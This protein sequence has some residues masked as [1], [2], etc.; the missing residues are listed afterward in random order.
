[1]IKKLTLLAMAI[2]AL[3]AFAAPAAAQAAEA[4]EGANKLAIGS[5]IT[6][7]STNLVTHSAL[8]KLECAKVTIHGELTENGPTVKG[9]ENSTTIEGCN[10]TITDPTAGTVSLS[11]GKGSTTGT[12]FVVEGFCSFTGSIPFSY[13]SGTD[14][15]TITGSNQLTSPFC[16]SATMTGSFTIT[17]S[18]G[19]TPVQIVG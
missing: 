18:N 6:L 2:T 4:K 3:V 16:G 19:T 10:R 7:T 8:G 14:V 5:K 13:V 15:A 17:T 11:G 1:M 9:K 12:K